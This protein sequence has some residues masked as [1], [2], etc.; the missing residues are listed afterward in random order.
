[1]SLIESMLNVQPSAILGE[2]AFIYASMRDAEKLGFPNLFNRTTRI[3]TAGTPLNLDMHEA[4]QERRMEVHDLYGCQEFG[5]IAC[6]GIPLRNDLSFMP[7][8]KEWHE[9]IVG[10]LPTGDCLI[11]SNSGHMCNR[12][13]RLITYRLKRSV[14]D[15]DI[16]IR[17]SKFKSEE[18]VRRIA[19]SILRLKGKHVYVSPSVRLGADC[20]VLELKGSQYNKNTIP[21]FCIDNAIKTEL[22]DSLAEAQCLYQND[23]RHNEVWS[24]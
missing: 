4:A 14:N 11:L 17:A 1:M 12:K 16:V 13:G 6:D 20:T 15:I 24:K 23:H 10:G 2:G 22:F 19:K 9:V 7:A 8:E 3:I 5:W 18:T 21:S